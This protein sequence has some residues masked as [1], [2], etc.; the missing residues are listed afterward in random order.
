[1]DETNVACL[2]DLCLLRVCTVLCSICGERQKS[3]ER[4]NHY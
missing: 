3:P 1:M 2:S 4:P